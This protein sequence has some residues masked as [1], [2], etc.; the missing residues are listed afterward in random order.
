MGKILISIFIFI[1]VLAGCSVASLPPG[2]SSHGAAPAAISDSRFQY[3][4]PYSLNQIKI[5]ITLAGLQLSDNQKINPADYRINNVTP[6]VYS[7]NYHKQTIL[8]YIFENI[9]E[10]KKVCWNGGEL[11]DIPLTQISQAENYLIRSYIA[12]NVLIV[13][14]LDASK[15]HSIPE[16]EQV[17]KP[18]R[19]VVLALNDAQKAVFSARG[20][21]WDAQYTVDYYQNWYKD[22]RGLT[23]VDQY[24]KG[25][26]TV[27]YI[28]PDPVAIQNINYEYKTPGRS[29][30]GHAV[31]ESIDEGYYLRLG[32]DEGGSIPAKDSV[33]SITIQWDGQEESLNL[34]MPESGH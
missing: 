18:V 14:M 24:S 22:N 6:F 25:K 32:H 3:P 5:A 2:N 10:R 30:S 11:S 13:D 31:L 16:I 7:V 19:E 9:A 17:L 20:N 26:W 29:G 12:R 23:R 15:M 1:T 33:Y 34:K 4:E 27:K 8:V 21:D 28:G